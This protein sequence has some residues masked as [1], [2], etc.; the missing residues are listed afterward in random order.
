M[1]GHPT[2]GHDLDG[3]ATVTAL[4]AGTTGTAIDTAAA[5]STRKSAPTRIARAEGVIAAASAAATTTT[6]TAAALPAATASTAGPATAAAGD[7]EACTRVRSGIAVLGGPTRIASKT[8]LPAG[9]PCAAIAVIEDDAALAAPA[10]RASEATDG[11]VNE[12]WRK[13]K[14]DQL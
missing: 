10:T 4:P 1:K 7:R 13:G 2:P 14:E 12:M 8:V 6:T 11:D 5:A 9:T 3:A